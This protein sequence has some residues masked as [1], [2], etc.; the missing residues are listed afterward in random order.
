MRNGLFNYFVGIS[1][2]I[3]EQTSIYLNVLLVEQIKSRETKKNIF[4]E[5]KYEIYITDN[6]N[7]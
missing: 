7:I 6:K 1:I 4:F 3:Y 2:V 5:I